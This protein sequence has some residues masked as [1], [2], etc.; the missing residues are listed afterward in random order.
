MVVPVVCQQHRER[1]TKNTQ[2]FGR[3][4]HNQHTHTSTHPL[5]S[6]FHLKAKRY[7]VFEEIAA[8]NY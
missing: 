8:T 1:Q 6:T 3:P 5:G 2:T 7:S 4:E